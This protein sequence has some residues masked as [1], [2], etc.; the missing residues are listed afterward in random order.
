MP[1]AAS[2]KF[3][4]F[5]VD[6]GAY[7]LIRDGTNIPLSPKIIDLLLFLAA[8]PSVLVSK[9]ELFKA[10]WP[11]VAVTDNALTQAVSELRQALGDDPANPKYVQTVA[12]RGY[13][14]ISPVEP[15]ASATAAPPS[16]PPV[17]APLPPTVGVLDFENVSGDLALAWLSSGIAET[18]TNDLRAGTPRIIDRVR[19]N[20]AVRQVGRDL[21]ALRSALGIDR[22]V[23]GSFQRAASRLRITGRI[24][25]AV[26][27]ECLADAKADGPLDEVFDL[28][29]RIVSQFI[30]ALG[31]G[32]PGPAERR[33][34][35]ETSS[36]EAY[37]AF[38]EGRVR[39]ESLDAA[40]VPGA[41]ADF[42]RAI[43]L[44]PRY[45]A[46]HVGLANARFW[47]YEMSRA[48]NQLDGA[49]LA[50]AID[51]V[52]KAIELERDLADAHATLA[53]LLVSAGRSVEAL[54]SAR[55]AVA[56]EPGYWG[57]QF[58]LAHAAWGEE[59]L[60]ALGRVM[61]LYPDFP[62]THFEAAMV[63]IARGTLDRA[64]STLREGTIVQDRQA[65]LRQRYPAKGLHW[66]LGVVRLA[67]GDASEALLEFDR[68]LASGPGQLYALEFAMNAHDGAA[69][70]HLETGDAGSAV[71]R[72]RK[73]LELFPEHARSLVGLG[74][75]LA[76]DGETVAADSAFAR[77][78]VAIEALRR[79]GRGA[80]ATLAE[81]FHH[82]V[83]GKP[84][85][86]V[87]A[88]HRLLEKA[89]LSFAGWT[90]PVEPLLE[91]LKGRPD[92]QAVLSRL[93]ERAR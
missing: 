47:Q 27:G 16:P 5:V 54:A 7:R 67:R 51:H 29:D 34:Y 61:E 23:V 14:F 60:N 46:A 90:I 49:L 20:E 75:A 32:K 80:E 8:R 88:L 84:V 81:A 38:T 26:T 78:A 10:L 69:F 53:F 70:A 79:G 91:K 21:A 48:R 86:A 83:R 55:R 6:G 41:I 74:A 42:E 31:A 76:A 17:E 66:L 30:E 19:V 22:A 56:L 68:E 58:R 37:Q 2:Y 93:A 45:A 57:N 4:P 40:L 35:R 43:A 13:R 71:G 36:L 50:R 82:A 72:F 73:A 1:T 24:I 92:Y 87:S 62:F 33:H 59:R 77:A 9:D 11:D 64:E 12:R 39:L 52:R 65:N 44:D 25:D 28:Q 89:D 63:H 18:I 15:I 85:D 3:G